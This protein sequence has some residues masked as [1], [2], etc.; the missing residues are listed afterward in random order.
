MVLCGVNLSGSGTS[1]DY[2]P[3]AGSH[4]CR[5]REQTTGEDVITRS[6]AAIESCDEN[7]DNF[8]TIPLTESKMR[9]QT[10]LLPRTV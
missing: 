4:K 10:H 2:P 7:A 9:A 6:S 8:R 3:T 5:S 1:A